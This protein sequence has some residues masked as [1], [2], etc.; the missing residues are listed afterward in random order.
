MKSDGAGHSVNSDRKV[1]KGEENVDRQQKKVEQPEQISDRLE[2][3]VSSRE[4]EK[5][6]QKV[7]EAREIRAERVAE[8]K[9]QLEAGTYN[10]K[11]EKVAE[12]IITGGLIDD[13]A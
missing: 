11:A 2:F 3:S 1:Q 8:I 13:K 7:D 4:F 5:L 6:R 10:I 9:Q 12:A